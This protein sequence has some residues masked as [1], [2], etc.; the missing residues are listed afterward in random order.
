MPG[1]SRR[2]GLVSVTEGAPFY[3][4]ITASFIRPLAL[5]IDPSLRSSPLLLPGTTAP[6][7]AGLS[8]P[9][10]ETTART[11]TPRLRL[12][13]TQNRGIRG[14]AVLQRRSIFSGERPWASFTSSQRRSSRRASTT[15]LVSRGQKEN[16][17]ERQENFPGSLIVW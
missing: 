10:D 2:H 16:F 13:P 4:P 11:D 7:V 8:F 12:R 17:A 15:L 1:P 14:G 9:L 5:S 6:F 3:G